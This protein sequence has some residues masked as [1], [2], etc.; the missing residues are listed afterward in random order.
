MGNEVI[1]LQ[2]QATATATATASMAKI[3]KL[4]ADPGSFD[5]SMAKFE[6]WWAKVKAWQAENHLAMPTNTDKPVCTVL[7]HLEGFKA[8][9]FA[10]MCLEILNSGA[11]YTWAWMCSKLEELFQPANQ[12]NC[13]QKKLESSNREEWW[14]M[15]GSSNSRHITNLLNSTIGWHHR[16]EHWS[17]HHPKNHW[18]GHSS[19][20][21]SWLSSQSTNNQ[22]KETTDLIPRDHKVLQTKRSQCYGCQCSRYFIRQGFQS[23][24][25]YFH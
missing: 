2:T 14:L 4:L 19:Y 9:S 24:H 15:N 1:A 20:W 8:G 5:G 3:S 25:R 16:G 13:A 23:S 22:S 21:P 10:G 18:R 12:K 7:S 6:E 17:I 11:A